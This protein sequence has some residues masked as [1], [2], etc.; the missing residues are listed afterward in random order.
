MPIWGEAG[1]DSAGKA[2]GVLLQE[3]GGR[4]PYIMREYGDCVG[5]LD[6]TDVWRRVPRICPRERLTK[7]GFE[8]P[9]NND[10][11]QGHLGGQHT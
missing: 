6:S 3:R 5:G 2:V 7:L 4:V 9:S 11:A 8:R 10:T 1:V